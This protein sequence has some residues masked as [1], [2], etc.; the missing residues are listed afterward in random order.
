MNRLIV[1]SL[2]AVLFVGCWGN[3]YVSADADLESVFMGKSYY[4]IVDQFGSPDATMQDPE[5][6]TC[7]AYNNATLKGTS[8]A[9][10]YKR[11]NIRNR[12]TREEDTPEGGITFSFNTRM[13]CYAVQSDFE[14]EK[15]KDTPK[16]EPQNSSHWVKPRVPRTLDFP[17][18]DSRSPYAQVVSI[19]R[20]EVERNYTKIYFSYCSRTPKHRPLY[21]KGL[22]INR[23][24]F[25]RDCATGKHISLVK[26]DGITLYPEYTKFA[27][28]RG[29]YDVLAYSLT[30]EALPM[31]TE[32]IDIIEPAAEG[33]N[34]YEVDVR[35]P[36]TFREV[37]QA[38][39]IPEN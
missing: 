36:M 30:F 5:G 33:F 11:Y 37:K 25:L 23:D 21:D 22:S 19:E 20:I 32:K 3:R 6:G 29:G 13:K 38:N 4:E 26:A 15:V 1:I 27:H 34:F 12:N 2:A 17:Y 24:V 28:N 10:L 16:K 7:I 35:T 8:A 39:P 18:V 31:E 14:R 9:I